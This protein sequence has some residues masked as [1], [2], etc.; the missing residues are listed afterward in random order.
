M[1]WYQRIVP[2]SPPYDLG[3][4]DQTRVMCAFRVDVVKEPSD[5]FLEEIV[6]VLVG[7]GTVVDNVTIFISSEAA[8]PED[9]E[10][11]LPFI[12]LTEDSGASS[13]Q[14]ADRPNAYERPT[15]K[16]IAHGRDY[17]TVRAL[18]R[19]AFLVLGRVRNIDLVP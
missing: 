15:A 13:I 3:P 9:A 2:V 16:L 5:T 7:A 12:H 11:A 4:D 8:L 1:T 19:E 6:G 17:K 14:V 18:A 10:D